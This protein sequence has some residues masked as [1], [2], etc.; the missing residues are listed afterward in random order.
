[1]DKIISSEQVHG[2]VAEIRN[3]R[4]GYVTNFYW[5]DQKHPYWVENGSLLYQKFEGCYLL[6]HNNGGFTNLFYIA[7]NMDAV[8]NAIQ[9]ASLE[10]DGVIDVVI[11]QEG[12][13]EVEALK[14][15][16]F[17]AYKYL[18]RMSHVGRMVGNDWFQDSRVKY[19]VKEDA[20]LVQDIFLRDFD[21]IAE[22]LPSIKEIEDFVDR[23]QLLVIKDEDKICGFLIYELTGV[24]WYL[25]YWYT[26]PEYRNKGIG[27]GLLRTSLLYGIESKRQ[28][29]WVISENENAIKRYEHYGFQKELVND[30]VMIKKFTPPPL[31]K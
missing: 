17:E 18:Y 2:F 16:G 4:Q 28:I 27:A 12:K 14:A 20:P 30:Y 23:K 13:G 21:P 22:Q 9:H 3:L 15:I 24:T 10:N 26:S 29:L 6:Q 11:K 25:R 19:A 1:M 7:C 31:A 8:T 5:D